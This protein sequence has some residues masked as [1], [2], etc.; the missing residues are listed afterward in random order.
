M[1]ALPDLSIRAFPYHFADY[2]V[3]MALLKGRPLCVEQKFVNFVISEIL[4]KFCH[5]KPIHYNVLRFLF[6]SLVV[7]YH[8]RNSVIRTLDG[9]GCLGLERDG[10]SFLLEFVV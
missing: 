8:I 10:F 1:P 6:Y 9:V 4:S 5:L 2:V 7:S 3:R